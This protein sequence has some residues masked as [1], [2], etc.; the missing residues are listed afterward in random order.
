[1]AKV[2]RGQSNILPEESPDAKAILNGHHHHIFMG[3][4]GLSIIGGCSTHYQ[5]TSMD[6]HHHLVSKKRIIL[7]LGNRIGK[8]LRRCLA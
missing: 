6:P 4:E 2:E 8:E 5:S 7:V 3:R 1:M